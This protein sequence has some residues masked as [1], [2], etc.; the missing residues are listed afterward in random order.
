LFKYLAEL[1][2]E[3]PQ[4]KQSDSP[5]HKVG[6]IL[7]QQ[8]EQVQH[9]TPMLSLNNVFY[10]LN[11]EELNIRH[12]EFLQFV[13]R[14]AKDLNKSPEQLEFV[15]SPKY[16]G[17]AISLIYKNGIFTQ[18]ITRGDGYYGE[19][20]THN[21]KTIRNLPLRLI[22]CELEYLEIRGEILILNKDFIK[23]NRMQ[24]ESGL[25]LYANP[26]NLAAGSIRQL[27]SS[28]AAGR[29]LYFFAYAMLTLD[30]ICSTYYQE[31]QL[32]KN[33]GFNIAKECKLVSGI[34]DLCVYYEEL[35]SNRSNLE[36]GIDGVVY[37][38]NLNKEQQKLGYITRAPRFAIAY[39]FP[40]IEVISQ[41]CEIHIQVGRTGALTPVAK[42]KP[43]I[44]DGVRVS[45]IS[46]YNHDDMVRKD[47]R[48]GDFVIIRRA[49]DV[50]PEI[51]RN[52]PDLRETELQPFLMPSNCPVCDS[53]LV[54]EA[55]EI[56]WRCPAGWLCKAQR[57]Q[58][59]IHYASKGAFNIDGLGE[60]IVV[61]LVE[62]N[63]VNNVTDLYR[64]T[65]MQL[66]NLERFAETKAEN[67]INSIQASKQVTLAKFIYA[68]GI[69]HIGEKTA[70]DLAFQ[71]GH[72]ENLSK[73]NFVELKQIPDIG[74]IMA[75]SIINFFA[76]QQNLQIINQLIE[77]GVNYLPEQ[78]QNLFHPLITG[79]NYVITG[80]FADYSRDEIIEQLEKFGAK[81]K[82]SISIK[83]DYLIYGANSGSKYTKALELNITLVDDKQ[84]KLLLEQ[85]Q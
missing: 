75:N 39:K 62:A 84:L 80:T 11:A 83:T 48:I 10:T 72:L 47:L 46:L 59:I 26:R 13:S 56:I 17:V 33:Y 85:L 66:V 23:L 14:L 41:I 36:F 16:D 31:L 73:A 22:N 60:K 1:E 52:L 50:I 42:I 21:V 43:V 45:S 35:L 71:F 57:I 81:I 28:I 19:D 29:P 34:D 7:L 4:F 61:Q 27:D 67:L 30:T 24:I 38:L 54:R 9:K 49:G 51:V 20:V 53:S 79:K 74:D 44:V 5:T 70:K 64:L 55:D 15:V 3:Y 6:G 78:R 37:K 32:L 65:V 18:A 68:L 8:F 76:N 12:Q 82:S 69:R 25:E 63:L 77:L 40:S 58:A 2:L